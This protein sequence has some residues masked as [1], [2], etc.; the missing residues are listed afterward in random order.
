MNKK[1]LVFS[2]VVL[3]LAA[4]TITALYISSRKKSETDGPSVIS[5]SAKA[6][7][8]LLDWDDPAGFAF[9]Y[10]EG[11]RVDKHDED[12]E[13]YAHVEFSDDRHPGG[14]I[15]WAKDTTSEDITAWV[16][17]E[18]EY[19]EASILDTTLGDTPAKK[20][21]L[22]SEGK[23]VT[24]AIY[25][26]LLFMVET[27]LGED[28]YWAEMNTQIIDTFSFAP[29]DDQTESASTEESIVDEEEVLE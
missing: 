25:D 21:L 17:T 20:I 2:V 23:V 12:Q 7:K 18:K 22:S 15:V 28:G 13:N 27:T 10:F 19:K 26:G 4:A 6:E 29:V 3:V 24:A 16:R 8:A 5:E 14:L 9:T 1:L 11:S